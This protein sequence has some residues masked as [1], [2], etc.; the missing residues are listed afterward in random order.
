MLTTLERVSNN[1]L[2]IIYL[3]EQTPKICLAAYDQNP[4]VF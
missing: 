3:E 2:C 1:G 4:D